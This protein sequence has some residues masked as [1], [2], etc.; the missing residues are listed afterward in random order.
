LN[1]LFVARKQK[2]VAIDEGHPVN[3]AS[4]IGPCVLV[5]QYLGGIIVIEW[6]DLYGVAVGQLQKGLS[7]PVGC[8]V[9]INVKLIEAH[10]EMECKPFDDVR[11]PVSLNRGDCNFHDVNNIGTI[12]R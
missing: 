6:D 9:A 1:R 12:S 4:K 2:L 10:G 8:F 7:H 3:N 5:R 11:I